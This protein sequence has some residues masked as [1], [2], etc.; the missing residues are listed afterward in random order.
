MHDSAVRAALRIPD[1]VPTSAVIAAPG[2]VA[3]M[4]QSGELRLWDSENDPRGASPELVG[5]TREG[6]NVITATPAGYVTG[7]EDGVLMLWPGLDDPGDPRRVARVPGQVI[8]MHTM[9]DGDRVIV[10]TTEGGW[11]ADVTDGRV[12]RI[13]T[14]NQFDAV[15]EPTPGR[16]LTAGGTG[17]SSAGAPARPRRRRSRS[18]APRGP[19]R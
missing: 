14:G 3:L 16:Y 1:V 11:L 4:G 6:F 19:S 18:T 12:Q 15:A 7:G 17:A 5:K 8:D 13:A 10:A 2:R 9:P